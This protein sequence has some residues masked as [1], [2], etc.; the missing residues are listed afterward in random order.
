MLALPLLSSTYILASLHHLGLQNAF[1]PLGHND[2]HPKATQQQLPFCPR[3][4]LSL[5]VLWT[6]ILGFSYSHPLKLAVGPVCEKSELKWEDRLHHGELLQKIGKDFLLSSFSLFS[7][8]SPWDGSRED[9]MP[10]FPGVFR[11]NWTAPYGTAGPLFQAHVGG[12][13]VIT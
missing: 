6:Q 13:K 1:Q 12:G 4:A 5:V 11:G 2:C 9:D 3:W 10:E 7:V 8:H